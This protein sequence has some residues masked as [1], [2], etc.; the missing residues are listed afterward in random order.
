MRKLLLLFLILTGSVAYSQKNIN[1][2]VIDKNGVP[3]SF[4]SITI[5]GKKTGTQSDQNGEFSLKV[6]LND[7]LVFSNTSFV[8]AE[9]AVNNANYYPVTLQNKENTIQEVVVTSAFNITRTSRS[10]SSNIQTISA[11]KLNTVRSTNINNA[12]AGKVAG[13]QVRSQSGA[14]LGRETAIR[15][16][17]EN[18]LGAGTGAIYVVD[19]TIVTNA[20][21]INLDDIEELNVL[22][23]PSAAALFG[24]D[25]SNG[26]V[27]VTTKKGRK[28][29]NTGIEIN[30]ALYFDNIFVTPQYQNAYAG[31]SAQDLYQYK[32]QTGQPEGWK[33]LDGKYYHDYSDDASWGPRI[34]GQEYIPWYA[35]Y[36]GHENSYKTAR[37]TPQPNNVRD[38][39]DR[40]V[41]KQNNINFVK[42]GDNFKLRISYTNLDVKGIMPG[43]YLQKNTFNSSMSVDISPSIAVNANI[44]YLNQKRNSENN[45]GYSNQS[46]GSFNQ[47]FHRDLDMGMMRSLR[48][49]RT[50]EGIYASWNHKNPGAYDPNNLVSFYGANFWLNPYTYFD[51]IKTPD[52][53]NRLYGDAGITVKITKDLKL[54]GT[55]RRNQL[56]TAG[57]LI[58]PIEMENSSSQSSFNPFEGNGLAGYGIDNS[59]DIRQNYELL[60]SYSKKI[61]S[62]Q[63]NANA[64]VDIL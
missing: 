7:V 52:T 53:R 28:N 20:N 23:G 62:F 5:K 2:K 9:I 22:Q 58:Y 45:D 46:A 35:W 49:L 48:N 3:V 21:D 39:Y 4:T 43:S 50:P 59:S 8:T 18:S 17:G 26:A 14:A 29:N 1:G 30:S 38:F 44:N 57:T 34:A 51:L 10:V 60:A 19:G 24:P 15:L 40:G 64:G 55:Y 63:I 31:G 25:G 36:G 32:W 47:W 42:G 61:K 54:R 12:L 33:A 13:V 37:L 11:D 27:V 16:R 56:N 41:T 6:S